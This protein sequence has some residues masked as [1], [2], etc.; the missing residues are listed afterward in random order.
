MNARRPSADDGPTIYRPSD[1]YA[2]PHPRQFRTLAVDPAPP[3][4][5]MPEVSLLTRV[6]R[7]RGTIL[8]CLVSIAAVGSFG[9]V[10][11]WA[12]TQ[13]IEAGGKGLAP[14]IKA[15]DRP[16]REKPANAGGLQV[17]Q[18][19][20][21]AFRRINPNAAP[22][23]PERLLPPPQQPRTPTAAQ[24]AQ[25]ATQPAAGASPATG[26][27]AAAPT[28]AAGDPPKPEPAK[29]EA[30]ETPGPSIASIVEGLSGPVGGWR[31]QLA[32]VP[33]EEVARTTWA[34]LQGANGDVLG[35]LRM[36]AARADL[37]AKGVW[38]RVQAGPLDEKQAQGA[39][40]RLKQRNVECI[41]VPPAKNG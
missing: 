5:A 3:P 11:W 25:A 15:E 38:Y 14:I 22:N 7:R 23:P 36:Q 35:Q 4:A 6:N 19:E 21:E 34:R 1:A 41:P 13:N 17:A 8:T 40:S 18:Q 27:A 31:I 30:A 10:V 39:C 32:S 37:G 33:N 16:I 24:L 26:A 12:H 20:N 9:G 2:E 28:V 29:A